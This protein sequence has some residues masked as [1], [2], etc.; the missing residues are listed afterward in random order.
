MPSPTK[1][2]LEELLTLHTRER[3]DELLK[4]YTPEQLL[5]I[6]PE[7]ITL[8]ENL[9]R[10]IEEM[11]QNYDDA[12][13]SYGVEE[14]AVRDTILINVHK[15]SEPSSNKDFLLPDSDIES[16]K[17]MTKKGHL[18][19]IAENLDD[20]FLPSIKK[21]IEGPG[22]D[23]VFSN[24]IESTT[25][26]ELYKQCK[27]ELELEAANPDIDKAKKHIDFNDVLLRMYTTESPFYQKLNQTIVG[28]KE[29]INASKE[30]REIALIMNVAL[31]KAGLE[32]AKHESNQT[33]TLLLRGQD[34]GNANYQEKFKKAQELLKNKNFANMSAEELSSIN[35]V[36]I[37]AKKSLSTTADENTAISFEKGAEDG[38]VVHIRNPELVADFYS[39]VNISAEKNEAE[40]MSRFPDD[41]LMIPVMS[42]EDDKKIPHIEVVCVRADSVMGFKASSKYAN[43]GHTVEKSI[44]AL[45]NGEHQHRHSDYTPIIWL[46]K[47]ANQVVSQLS[48]E[49]VKLLEKLDTLIKQSQALGDSIHNKDA[50]EKFLDECNKLMVLLNNTPH[51][52]DLKP[53]F[54]A[55]N[56]AVQAYMAPF[57]EA[58]ITPHQSLEDRLEIQESQ[59][60]SEIYGIEAWMQEKKEAPGFADIN[61]DLEILINP[62]STDIEKIKAAQGVSDKLAKKTALDQHFPGL[63]TS[64]DSII[65]SINKLAEIKQK[66]TSMDTT[67]N[68]RQAIQSATNSKNP[69]TEPQP[70]TN[71]TSDYKSALKDKTSSNE[72]KTDHK[73]GETF[74]I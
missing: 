53:E 72:P 18:T 45:L 58:K 16:L 22:G 30:V 64:V 14:E 28:Y 27:N 9:E 37:V 26:K 4:R 66:K 73:P 38:V 35:I 32:K 43:L 11:T 57:I 40:Y 47:L 24:G 67:H 61:H 44:H 17:D 42:Y 20:S 62:K 19:L 59:L 68:Y 1:Q 31:H 29:G 2:H 8:Q 46:N 10:A 65:S 60:A 48:E 33:P 21:M 7:Q 54:R 69:G 39:V 23:V 63:K 36:D 71:V 25:L 13:H 49:Q 41:I 74:E 56:L 55:I 34:F 70:L 51:G 15:W 52:R 50:Q 12:H 5:W 3:L 6:K